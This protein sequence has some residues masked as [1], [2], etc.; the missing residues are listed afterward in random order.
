[1]FEY[2]GAIASPT[3]CRCVFAQI[4]SHRRFKCCLIVSALSRKV[5]WLRGSGELVARML[6]SCPLPSRPSFGWWRDF[7]SRCNVI[8]AC[9][10]SEVC[11]ALVTCFFMRQQLT[12]AQLLAYCWV[13]SLAFLMASSSFCFQWSAMASSRGS[14][15]LG[16]DRSA[17]MESRTYC[18]MIIRKPKANK[19][20]TLVIAL[21]S[22]KLNDLQPWSAGQG[23]TWS[24]GCPSKYGLTRIMC[25]NI[26]F[27]IDISL[28]EERAEARGPMTSD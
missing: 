14:S 23:T 4:Q 26:E 18:K 7:D 20:G 15:Q 22:R 16:A 13:H 2:H 8:Q 12:S 17:W 6:S 19:N 5:R 28:F 25:V 27:N 3:S 1:M 10:H 11:Q 21:V 24:S 9:F